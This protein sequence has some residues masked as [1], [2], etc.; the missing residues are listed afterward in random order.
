MRSTSGPWMTLSQLSASSSALSGEMHR[1]EQRLHATAPNREPTSVMASHLLHAP[2]KRIRPL[3][4]LSA[5][6]S[7]GATL[8]VDEQVIDVAVAVE[9]LHAASLCHDDVLD[10][11]PTRRGRPTLN[12][13]WGPH[14]AVLTGDL[15]LARAYLVT[16]GLGKRARTRMSET[17]VALCEGQIA[18]SSYRYRT[19]R[20]VD[21]YMKAVHGKTAALLSFST[22]IGASCANAAED[23]AD[24]LGAY[25]RDL[26]VTFQLI[27]DLLDIYSTVGD[28]G[29]ATGRD[30]AEGVYTLPVLI[31][32]S[33]Y[34]SLAELLTQPPSEDQLAQLRRALN[35][36]GA[37][38]AAIEMASS[39]GEGARNHL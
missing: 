7:L 20:P 15:L 33:R 11:A 36:T 39:F 34:P 35:E 30:I 2:G 26:G 28:A 3:L 31:A 1:V 38:A 8:P 6:M 27:D 37:I 13:L 21:E 22:W 25:G 4:V 12:V 32:L 9:L 5:A 19:D 16:S 10:R 14:E 17:L 29:K 23:T 24:L 18:E